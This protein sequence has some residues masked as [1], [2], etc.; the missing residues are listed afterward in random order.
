MLTMLLVLMR[1][2]LILTNL[3]YPIPTDHHHH[4]WKQ[5]TNKDLYVKVPNTLMPQEISLRE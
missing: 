3:D 1:E 4:Q 5:S 2:I